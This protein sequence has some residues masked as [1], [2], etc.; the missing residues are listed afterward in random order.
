MA[1]Y[2]NR[3]VVTIDGK[4]ESNFKAVKLGAEEHRVQV[5][6]MNSTGT[7]KKTPRFGFSLDYVVPETGEI[8]WALVEDATAKIEYENGSGVVYRRVSVK[9]VGE[10][11]IDG[12]G[13][14]VKTIEFIAEEK[15][16]A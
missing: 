8:D 11:N 6:L 3:V 13:E 15:V 12:E 9:S 16:A 10:T 4:E 5:N 2:V 14:V 1:N 7:S